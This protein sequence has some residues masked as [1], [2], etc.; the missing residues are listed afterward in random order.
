MRVFAA[1]PLSAEALTAVTA[2]RDRLREH[3]WPV[4]WVGD[5]GLHL[6]VRF[7]G[8]VADERVD[9][10]GESLAQAVGRMD[11][12]GIELG[13]L[14]VFPTRRKP[15]VIWMGVAAPPALEQLHDRVERA[16]LTGDYPGTP[17]RE[18]YRPH[19]TLGRVQRRAVLAGDVAEVLDRVDDSVVFQ[20]DRVVLYRSR[21]ARGGVRYHSLRIIPFEG[22][23]AV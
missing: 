22:V 19:V 20:A 15:R 13:G 1:I 6:T 2:V 21:A 10:L 7:Y 8:E 4:R 18:T 9:G 23:W 14:G 17:A 16:A 3:G 12:L 5:E 11:P